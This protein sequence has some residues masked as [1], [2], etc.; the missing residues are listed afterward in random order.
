MRVASINIEGD[1]HLDL[2]TN[3]LA[4]YQPVVV[5]LQEVFQTDIPRLQGNQYPFAFYAPTVTITHP[6]QYRVSPRGIMGNLILSQTP[7]AVSRHYYVGSPDTI[8]E[9]VDGFPNSPNRVV[10]QATW[11]WEE[12]TYTIANTH[13]TWSTGGQTS[14]EQ[15]RTLAALLGAVADWPPHIL[16][17]DFNAP[18]GREIWT[19]LTQH[20]TDN[21]P[22]DIT[23][24]IDGNLHRA[25]PLPIV[26]DGIFSQPEYQVGPV[27]VMTGVSDHCAVLAEIAKNSLTMGI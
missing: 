17:G 23:T 3:W 18:R 12:D 25:G 2:V 5:A 22:S 7:M 15:R 19:E 24:T 26:V 16:V 13:F 1:L 8:P 9:L 20:Y 21:I 27:T 4:R 6:N 14:D 11:L 10:Q